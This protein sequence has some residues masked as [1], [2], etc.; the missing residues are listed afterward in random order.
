[1]HVLSNSNINSF[2]KLIDQ[3]KI[4]YTKY[5]LQ[6]IKWK[7]NCE[8]KCDKNILIVT[9]DLMNFVRQFLKCDRKSYENIS[10]VIEN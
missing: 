10:K 8:L 2:W 6:H 7:Q 9:K 5:Q 1:M 4:I 3:N